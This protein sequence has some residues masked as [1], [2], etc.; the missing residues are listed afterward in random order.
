M[1]PFAVQLMVT[2]LG[3]AAVPGL[4]EVMPSAEGSSVQ[5]VPVTPSI[6]VP[7]SFHSKVVSSG[8]V[9]TGTGPLNTAGDR[10]RL[11]PSVRLVSA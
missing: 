7:F 4:E 6:T 10:F 8:T 2:L 11:K 3:K 9:K 1:G 5:T